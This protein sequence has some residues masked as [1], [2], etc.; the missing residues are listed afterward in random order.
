MHD[1]F[2]D[3]LGTDHLTFR[4]GGVGEMFFPLAR[5]LFSCKTKIRFFIEH[6]RK[7]S[8]F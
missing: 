8:N 7:I 5:L 4:E 2:K 6:E 3:M 1:K